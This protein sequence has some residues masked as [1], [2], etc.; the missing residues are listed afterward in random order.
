MEAEVFSLVA[1]VLALVGVRELLVAMMKERA[2]R[3]DDELDRATRWRQW[4]RGLHPRLRPARASRSV[5]ARSP[6]TPPPDPPHT[7][8][9]F[10][11]FSCFGVRTQ[12]LKI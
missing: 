12:N 2:C 10:F 7:Q 1:D 5:L 9:F 4:F 11:F 6:R 3:K 8:F